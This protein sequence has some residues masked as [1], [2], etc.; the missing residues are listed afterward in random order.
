MLYGANSPVQQ[1]RVKLNQNGNRAKKHREGILKNVQK[2][3]FEVN[4]LAVEDPAAKWKGNWQERKWK[5]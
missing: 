5:I 2:P 4:S 1:E 3:R